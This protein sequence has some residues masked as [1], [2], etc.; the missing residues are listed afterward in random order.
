GALDVHLRAHA[1]GDRIDD[2]LDELKRIR[3]EAGWPPLAAPI[4]QILASQALIHVLSAS[5]YETVVDELRDL[6]E[7]RYGSP[8]APIDPTVRRAVELTSGDGRV[9][10]PTAEL[11]ELR[12]DAEGLASSEE[13]LLLLALFGDDAAPLLRSI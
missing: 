6:F 4:G 1:A 8:P 2:V 7:G 11:D 10:E 9:P 3:E 5:R 12:D 13:E